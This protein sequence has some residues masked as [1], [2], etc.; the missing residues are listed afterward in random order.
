M[1][2]RLRTK[3]IDYVVVLNTNRLWRSD[4]VKVLIHR[5]FNKYQV[6]VKVL[7]NRITVFIR[8]IQM[9]F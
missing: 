1:L 3:D 2:S 5:E 4:I 7:N 9:T 8:K 6:D